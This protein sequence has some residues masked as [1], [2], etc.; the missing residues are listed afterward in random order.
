MS[1]TRKLSFPLAG[2]LSFRS[3][4]GAQR[5][6]Y[7]RELLRD[8]DA[9]R[10]LIGGPGATRIAA[11]LRTFG[12]DVTL[13]D[14]ATDG[15]GPAGAFDVAIALDLQSQTDKAGLRALLEGLR[16]RCRASILFVTPSFSDELLA[17]GTNAYRIIETI[18][19]WQEEIQAVFASTTRVTPPIQTEL[20][21]LSWE[22]LETT[23]SRLRKRKQIEGLVAQAGELVGSPLRMAANAWIGRAGLKTFEKLVAGQRVAIVGNARAIGAQAQGVQIDA[24][25]VV[26]RLNRGPILSAEVSGRRTTILATRRWVPREMYDRRRLRLLIWLYPR[27]DD[28]PLWLLLPGRNAAVFPSVLFQDLKRTLGKSPS[29][30]IMMIAATLEC[31]PEAVTL[32]GFDAYSSRSLSGRSIGESVPHDFAAEARHIDVLAASNPI[33]RRA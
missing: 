31:R 9:H 12:H 30:G 22:P 11:S 33:L 10:L 25:D 13:Y 20:C 3:D 1:L 14:P 29:S 7:L 26:I 32:F 28:F 16:A 8:A 18:D 27:H 17:D 5:L 4:L 23:R 19:W 21:F 2:L 15:A 6:P 24:H